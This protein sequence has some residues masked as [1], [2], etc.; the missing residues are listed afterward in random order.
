MN[1][2]NQNRWK[3]EVLEHILTALAAHTS[4]NQ[5]IIF[6]GARILNLRL[7]NTSRQSLDI[8]SSLDINCA[9]KKEPN[10]KIKEYLHTEIQSALIRFFNKQNPMRYVLTDIK[11]VMSPRHGEHP[12]GWSGY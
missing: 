12:F 1:K 9:L 7:D 6:K 11:V 2:E 4:L 5:N 10:E 3:N 8:D